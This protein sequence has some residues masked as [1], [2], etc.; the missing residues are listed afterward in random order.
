MDKNIADLLEL[1]KAHPELPI[2]PMVDEDSRTAES[3]GRRDAPEKLPDH[4]GREA[5]SK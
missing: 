5:L 2:V 4:K 1:I 3:E